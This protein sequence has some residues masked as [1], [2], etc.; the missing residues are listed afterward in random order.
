MHVQLVGY[1]VGKIEREIVNADAL[2][3]TTLA[4]GPALGPIEASATTIAYRRFGIF[5]Y[6]PNIV[7]FAN[8]IGCF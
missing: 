3:G 5:R 7:L 2:I 1:S 4:Y 8:A 6:F